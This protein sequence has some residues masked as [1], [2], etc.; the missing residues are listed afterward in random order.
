M[1]SYHRFSLKVSVR[2]VVEPKNAGHRSGDMCSHDVKSFS[3]DVGQCA[4]ASFQ[5][6]TAPVV[7][8]VAAVT[9]DV[10]IPPVFV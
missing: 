3:S 7:C 5:K 1:S 10:V 4:R 2:H 8:P 6:C 9:A